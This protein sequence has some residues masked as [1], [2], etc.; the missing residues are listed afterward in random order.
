MNQHHVVCQSQR[1]CVLQPKVGVPAPTLGSRSK[2][3]QPQRGC[4]HWC[5]D[6]NG[7]AQPRCGWKFMRTLTLWDGIPL[8]FSN[9]ASAWRIYETKPSP[10]ANTKQNPRWGCAEMTN[11]EPRA[12]NMIKSM[13]TAIDRYF[14]ERNQEFRE[15]PKRAGGKIWGNENVA[16][17]FSEANNCKNQR[18]MNAR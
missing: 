6:E 16:P 4:G 8:G 2:W 13:V 12:M 7:M 15:H 18:Y 3:K 5:A 10:D 17:K 11:E 9:G 1:D 14:A